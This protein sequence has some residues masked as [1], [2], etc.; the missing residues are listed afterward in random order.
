MSTDAHELLALAL[1]TEPPAESVEAAWRVE[2]ERGEAE[3]LA[4]SEVRRRM[5][6]AGRGRAR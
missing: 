3:T 2:V 1:E 4:W 6:D 5:M